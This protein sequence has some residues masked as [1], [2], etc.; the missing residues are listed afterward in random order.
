[1]GTTMIAF[2]RYDTESLRHRLLRRREEVRHQIE[3]VTGRTEDEPFRALTG[4]VSDSNDEA[5]ATT[6]L[7]TDH[8]AIGRDLTEIREI[9]AALARLDHGKY[10]ECTDCE[11][12][13][14]VN[15]LNAQ[16]TALRCF[17]CQARYE[18][19]HGQAASKL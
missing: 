12:K 1:M 4:E 2:E 8:A 17:Q 13:I 5:V 9:E 11:E 19:A 6:L 16:P 18:H 3:E 7:D 10:G 15:R 14:D